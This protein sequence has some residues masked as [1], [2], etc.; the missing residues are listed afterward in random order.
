MELWS[1]ETEEAFEMISFKHILY[2]IH[3]Q[4]KRREGTCLAQIQKFCL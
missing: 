4:M 2:F 1:V 3:E